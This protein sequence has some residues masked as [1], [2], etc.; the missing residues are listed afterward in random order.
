MTTRGNGN[1]HIYTTTTCR[2][3]THTY[4]SENKYKWWNIGKQEKQSRKQQQQG[5]HIPVQYLYSNEKNIK[6][7]TEQNKTKREET[8]AHMCMGDACTVIMQLISQSV[9]HG[10]NAST[11]GNNLNLTTYQSVSTRGLFKNCTFESTGTSLWLTMPAMTRVLLG[12]SYVSMFFITA[13][14]YLY[15][16]CKP[17]ASKN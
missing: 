8:D 17:T 5:N 1:A 16:Y 11:Q 10:K 6:Q 3:P 13:A 15:R 9:M 14:R 12:H 7:L 2:Q 4:S